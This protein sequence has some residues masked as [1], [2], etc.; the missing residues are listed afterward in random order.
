MQPWPIRQGDD[1]LASLLGGSLTSP[2]FVDTSYK[3]NETI[4]VGGMSV[5]IK[6]QRL[7]AHGESTTVIKFLKPSFLRT[8][9]ALARIVVEKE[10]VSL[11]RLNERVPSTPFVVRLLDAG[12]LAV[13][14][15]K[16]PRLDL[17]WIALE[18][19][20][21]GADGTT[22]TE[23]VTSCVK[24]SGFAFD[25]ERAMR[26]VECLSE[27]L[28]A[29][30]EM[31]VIHRD[32]KPDNILCCG[33]GIEEV[34]KISDF[35][36]A[37]PL[38]RRGDSAAFSGLVIGSPGYAAPEQVDRDDTNLGP[39]ADVFSMAAIVFY[40]LTGEKYFPGETA[41]RGIEA[42]LAKGR[43]RLRDCAHLDPQLRDRPEACA[44]IDAILAKA[45]SPRVE[46][47]PPSAR[48]LAAEL[49]PCFRGDF[50]RGSAVSHT[51]KTGLL[52]SYTAQEVSD[53]AALARKDWFIRYPAGSDRKIRS[54]AWNS[55]G[56]CL[57]SSNRGVEF[58]DGTRWNPVKVAGDMASDRVHAIE[59]LAP[60]RWLMADDNGRF[61][62]YTPSGGVRNIV[63]L[64]NRPQIVQHAS[65]DPAD[66]LVMVA[67]ASA[68]RPWLYAMAARRAVL[69]IPLDGV[70]TIGSLVRLADS[71]W[72]IAGRSVHGL[73]YAAIY[74]PL[75]FQVHPLDAPRTAAFLTAA[76][77]HGQLPA[78]MAGTDGIVAW[79]QDNA[80]SYEK[81]PVDGAVSAV[82]LDRRLVAWGATP[83]ALWVRRAT[84]KT[85]RWRQVWENPSWTA[86][87]VSIR[88]SFERVLAI[89]SDGGILE[90]CRITKTSR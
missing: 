12:T 19:V 9:K 20:H 87:F 36:I 59:L 78:L 52:K 63:A 26:A 50:D 1:D 76:A 75:M 5:A 22:L 81:I 67:Q 47:R 74:D 4:A 65:G 89:T 66:L 31:E 82:A 37:R 2:N 62:E 38:G 34:L 80:M 61:G 46:D 90:G 57:A 85:E 11:M 24:W 73:A 58:W 7:S 71:R 56:T 8:D 88:A 14:L 40:L 84:S 10:V 51:G 16:G 35:G 42:M 6:A 53:E 28:A 68:G 41:L 70:A 45:T 48:R 23:R 43:R 77:N 54:V 60:G 33:V 30:H 44:E 25:C 29:I 21:G 86:P 27:G 72:L 64:T 49:A 3:L 13:A 39:T 18:Y 79:F 15:A 17:P 69:P 55:D 83:G 32:L